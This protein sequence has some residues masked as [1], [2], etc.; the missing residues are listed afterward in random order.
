M[1]KEHSKS[2]QRAGLLWHLFGKKTRERIA[3]EMTL[4]ELRHLNDAYRAYR[5]EAPATRRLVESETRR[6]ANLRQSVVPTYLFFAGIAFFSLLLLLHFRTYPDMHSFLRYQ[7]FTPLM[8]AV[9]SP[10]ACY[11]VP[12]YRL[13]LLFRIDISQESAVIVFLF[14]LGLLW[15]L[16]AI[17][18]AQGG[19]AMK[20]S[21]LNLWVLVVGAALAPFLEEVAFREVLPG[22]F[23]RAPHYTGHLIAATVFAAAHIPGSWW[24]FFLYLTAALFLAAVRLQTEGLLYPL[25]VHAFANVSILL[26][27]SL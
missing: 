3:R 14:A 21:G 25:V 26:V 2:M 18:D 17:G 9:V 4:E 23:G 16:F 8:L 6:L 11:F 27:T 22:M 15:T 7:I 5:E 1:A 20:L 19:E 10:L 12:P 24:M 13:R